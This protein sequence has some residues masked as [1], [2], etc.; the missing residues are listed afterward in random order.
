MAQFDVRHA[1]IMGALVALIAWRLYGRIKRNIGRQTFK[2]VRSWFNVIFF[3]LI[4]AFLAYSVHLQPLAAGALVAGALIG[5]TL[6]IVGVRLTRFEITPQGRFYTPSAH[7]GIA[8]SA[9]VVCRVLYRLI[10]M[11]TGTSSAAAPPAPPVLT[12]LTMVI[13]GALAGYYV[14]YAIGLL[15]WAYRSRNE[16]AS[17]S[18]PAGT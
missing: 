6:G 2:P 12:P 11:G 5:V 14:T 10:V 3:P 13:V 9:L 16:L 17:A 1:L 18:S 7:I 4:V 8:L 15:R